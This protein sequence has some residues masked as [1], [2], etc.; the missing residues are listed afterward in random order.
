MVR[1]EKRGR[2][3]DNVRGGRTEIVAVIRSAITSF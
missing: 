1:R 2:G 3:S